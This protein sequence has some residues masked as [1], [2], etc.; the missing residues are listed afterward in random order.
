ME[1][2]DDYG[3]VLWLVFLGCWFWFWIWK[4]MDILIEFDLNFGLLGVFWVMFFILMY[5]GDMDIII[6]FDFGLVIFIFGGKNK[7]FGV[8]ILC[9]LRDL[10]LMLGLC[11]GG[12]F[13]FSLL[14]FL[15]LFKLLSLVWVILFELIIVC[16]EMYFFC[17]IVELIWEILLVELDEVF[18][19][20]D[21][22]NWRFCFFMV[23]EFGFWGL[24]FDVFRL[25]IIVWE[26]NFV[27]CEFGFD[28]LRELCWFLVGF[29][30][31][32][33]F[34]CD[35]C[36]D[37]IDKMVFCVFFFRMLLLFGKIDG[38]KVV[39][40]VNGKIVIFIRFKLVKSLNL[41]W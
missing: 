12:Y 21:G 29:L 26:V 31:R 20:L 6:I 34:F 30:L 18:I 13:D 36:F 28:E 23:I 14:I 11:G 35:W 19:F 10:F 27:F 7:C 8:E 38:F 39:V 1:I 32:K 25:I 24:G 40:R 3:F 5:E 41:I 33:S 15:L 4:G 9:K 37:N 2:D 16:E 17:L 22:V